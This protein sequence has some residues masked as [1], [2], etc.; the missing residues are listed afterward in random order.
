M[1]TKTP[2]TAA[3]Y[4]GV[5]YPSERFRIHAQVGTP[6]DLCCKRVGRESLI[7]RRS[8]FEAT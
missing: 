6:L 4:L 7:P 1:R 5:W 3:P 2:D 8:P